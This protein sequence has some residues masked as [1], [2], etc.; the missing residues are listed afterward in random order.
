MRVL[1]V[2]AEACENLPDLQYQ[3]P[4]KKCGAERARVAVD[5]GFEGHGIER[6]EKAS[7]DSQIFFLDCKCR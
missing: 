2:R 1:K 7:R 3:T 5:Q 6:Y 4:A